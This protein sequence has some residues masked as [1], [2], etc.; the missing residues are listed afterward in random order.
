MQPALP[1]RPFGPNNGAPLFGL[2]FSSNDYMPLKNRYKKYE[3]IPG[4]YEL[5][6]LSNRD[7]PEYHIS[8][9]V[10]DYDVFVVNKAYRLGNL[11]EAITG[12]VGYT[13]RRNSK[14]STVMLFTDDPKEIN[15]VWDKREGDFRLYCDIYEINA[16]ANR[17][18]KTLKWF[19]SLP[20]PLQ[21]SVS[22][23]EARDLLL[24]YAVAAEIPFSTL[25]SKFPLLS[26][27][28]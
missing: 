26:K 19:K 5:K 21:L 27:K 17:I 28:S 12:V 9:V 7:S 14:S 20:I 8:G 24:Q 4:V 10:I 15:K 6:N 18:L 16:Y 22:S 1:D 11:R 13:G 3:V 25:V 2:V 23:D